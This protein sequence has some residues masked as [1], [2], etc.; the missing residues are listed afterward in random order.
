[1]KLTIVQHVSIPLWEGMQ[2]EDNLQDTDTHQ[3]KKQT[4]IDAGIQWH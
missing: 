3:D 1:M 4:K 2:L